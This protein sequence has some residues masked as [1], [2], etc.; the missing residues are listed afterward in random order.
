MK[1]LSQHQLALLR[2][3]CQYSIMDDGVRCQWY[4]LGGSGFVP[5]RYNRNTMRALSEVSLVV[6]NGGYRATETGRKL[7]AELDKKQVTA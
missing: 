4:R 3:C 7:V 2:E 1:K 5:L 6:R